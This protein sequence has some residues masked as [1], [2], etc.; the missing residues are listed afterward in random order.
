M[1]N[2]DVTAELVRELF[3]YVPE[4]GALTRKVRTAQSVQVGDRADK[5][6]KPGFNDGCL[7]V[8]IKNV[9]FL[10]H[11]IVWLHQMGKW[12]EHSIDHINGNRMDN[13]IENLRDVPHAINM[14][15]RRVPSIKN[16]S[17]FQGVQKHQNK[18]RASV[19]VNRVVHRIGMF[20]TPEE[21]HQA[22]VKAK[23][24]MHEGCTL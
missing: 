16:K 3:E 7:R 1:A 15:N 2:T 10:A 24:E 5:P 19:T 9:K 6:W 18:W 13:R 12:P 23:R 8:T 20:N 17:G 22:Y 14:Q 11:R 4:T 21:A